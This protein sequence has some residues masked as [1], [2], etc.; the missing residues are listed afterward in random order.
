[1]LLDESNYSAPTSISTVAWGDCCGIG[2]SPPDG[3]PNFIDITAVVLGFQGSA[4]APFLP[5][6]DLRGLGTSPTQHPDN[7]V[8]FVDISAAVDA[9]QGLPYP[10]EL[11]SC[12]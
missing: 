9:F 2:N 8:D 1:M 3:D 6:I 5:R 10:S 7:R 4:L 11:S 12:P